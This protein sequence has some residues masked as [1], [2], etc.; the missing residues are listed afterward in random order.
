MPGG[1]NSPSPSGGRSGWG[2]VEVLE[3][4]EASASEPKERRFK[5]GNVVSLFGVTAKK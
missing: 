1:H 3:C 5:E 2:W 4:F